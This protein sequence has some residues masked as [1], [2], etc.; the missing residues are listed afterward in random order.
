MKSR[1]KV[2]V[3]LLACAVGSVSFGFSTSAGAEELRWLT[4][5]A[6]DAGD[7]MASNIQWFADQ[8]A[9]RT[10]GK[11]TIK[12]MWGG[13]AAAQREIP[14]ALSSGVGQIGDV[15][16]PYYMDKFVLNNA[17]GFFIPQPL[18]TKQLGDMMAK[19]HSE[20]PQFDQEMAKYNLKVVGYRPLESYGLLCT[21][22]VHKLSDLTGKRIRSYGTA[23]PPLIEA[24]K[25]TPVTVSTT[26]AYQALQ[27][28]IIDC[29]P[30]GIT[31]TDSFKY[32]EV[33]KYY[34]N[35]PFGSN[36]GQFIVMNLTA[37]NK[38]SEE[39]RSVIDSLGRQNVDDF[40]KRMVPLQEAVRKHWKE[41]GVQYIDFPA[42]TF[43]DVIKA[44]KVQAIRQTWIDAA[45]KAGLPSEKLAQEML[46]AK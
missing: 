29:T 14:D 41:L 5:K 6:K 45:S 44:P 11:V 12:V 10:D 27:R 3:A 42:D 21:K 16:M 39:A 30:T 18:N 19:W 25:A 4:W 23:Y 40:V 24:L 46:S 34:M 13:S 17:F 35:L 1:K 33:A 2:L 38:L 26:E 37:Y 22:P 15:V 31:Y 20:Y 36:F 9:A 7:V 28:G 43:K 8:V 32:D